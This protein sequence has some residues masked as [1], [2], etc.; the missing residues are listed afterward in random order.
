MKICGAC[1]HELPDQ[2]RFC[3][4]CGQA[5]LDSSQARP[6]TKPA[7]KSVGPEAEEMNMT[8]LYVMVG[9]LGLALLFPPWETP[10]AQPP[11]FLGF[12]FILSPPESDAV[13]SRLLMTIELVTIAVAGFYLSW[14]FRKRATGVPR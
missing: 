13:V 6:A 8:V 11:E 7:T 4:R 3:T 14:L 12:H 5:V 1:G 10:P 2:S 9:L